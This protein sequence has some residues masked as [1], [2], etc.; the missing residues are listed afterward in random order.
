MEHHLEP[1]GKMRKFTLR[2]DVSKFWN[3]RS[4][5]LSSIFL[6]GWWLSPTPLK[7][8]S[9]GKIIPNIWKNKKCSKP[10]TS[11]SSWASKTKNSEGIVVTSYDPAENREWIGALGALIYKQKSDIH[12]SPYLNIRN[13]QCIYPLVN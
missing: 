13:C 8:K 4:S 9:V 10:P 1:L 2:F 5:T 6:T 3:P 12:V 11:L 7:K